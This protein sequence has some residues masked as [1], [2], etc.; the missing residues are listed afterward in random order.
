MN[1]AFKSKKPLFYHGDELSCGFGSLMVEQ[2]CYKG[3][4]PDPVSGAIAGAKETTALYPFQY[5][6]NAPSQTGG[7]ATLIDPATGKPKEYDFSGAGQQQVQGQISDKMAQVMLDIQKGYG[8]QYIAQRLKDLEQSDPEGYAARKQLFDQIQQE[9]STNPPNEPLSEQTQKSISEILTASGKLTPEEQRQ[10]Q[11][12]VRG[13]NIASGVYLGGA[14]AQKEASAT[15]GALDQKQQQG[16][17]AAEQYLSMGVTPSDIQYQKIQQDLANYGAF[18]NKQT[19]TAQFGQL[20]GAQQGAAP[21]SSSYQTPGITG[22]GQSAQQGMNWQQGIYG[23]QQ[24]IANPYMAGLSTLSQGIGIA[25][26]SGM[27][28]SPSYM[29]SYAGGAISNPSY[30][31]PNASGAPIGNANIGGVN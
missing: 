15:V 19:P 22:I 11:Q 21:Y 17:S 31:T 18:I 25:G 10:V 1:I 12:G 16:Q 28:S 2:R 24:N 5:I 3:S 23:A 7:K 30:L 6:I 26:Q 27:F 20:Q 8:P 29:P 14:P 13:Q 4:V 9:A